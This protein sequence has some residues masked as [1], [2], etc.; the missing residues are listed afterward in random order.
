MGLLLSVR[1]GHCH[2]PGT[3][4][5]DNAPACRLCLRVMLSRVLEW[6][7]LIVNINSIDVFNLLDLSFDPA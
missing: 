4:G 3:T 7:E 1:K 5:Q 6:N 2:D